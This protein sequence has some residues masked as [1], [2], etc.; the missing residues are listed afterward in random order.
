MQSQ[1]HTLWLNKEGLKKK[2]KTS[3]S[4]SH[5]ELGNGPSNCRTKFRGYQIVS[6]SHTVIERKPW[7]VGTAQTVLCWNSERC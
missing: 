2:R 1:K 4:F 6:L 5:G 7:G 3:K